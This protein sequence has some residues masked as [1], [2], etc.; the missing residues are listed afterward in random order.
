[1]KKGDKVHLKGKKEISGI[2]EKTKFDN[3][4]GVD[5]MMHYVKYDKEDLIPPADWHDEVDLVLIEK[6]ELPKGNI[7]GC[8]CGVL[9]VMPNG[10]HS[11]YCPLYKE[12]K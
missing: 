1:M 3:I 8:E 11:S 10:R 6:P 5:Y 7:Y 9:H 2:I 4:W 12:Y